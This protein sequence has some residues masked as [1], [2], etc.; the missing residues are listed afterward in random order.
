MEMSGQLH[1][2]TVLPPGKGPLYPLVGNFV[3]PRVVVISTS[4]GYGLSGN[5]IPELIN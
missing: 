1:V 4:L 2:A 5:N 3:G